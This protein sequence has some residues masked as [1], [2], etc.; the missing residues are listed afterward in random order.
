MDRRKILNVSNNNGF[1]PLIRDSRLN[2]GD[3]L[4]LQHLLEYKFN[5]D[6]RAL[7]ENILEYAV[8]IEEYEFA[9]IIRDELQNNI[10]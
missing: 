6:F 10:K 2:I 8:E 3:K 7:I 4:A 1:Y 9:A 5:N